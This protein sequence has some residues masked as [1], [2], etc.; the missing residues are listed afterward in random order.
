M[1]WQTSF[2]LRN[3]SNQ[4]LSAKLEIEDAKMGI[5]NT[6]LA[7]APTALYII[8]KSSLLVQKI[9]ERIGTFKRRAARRFMFIPRRR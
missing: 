6:K 8:H 3:L 1:E 4:A 2:E 5:Q 7:R 9:V